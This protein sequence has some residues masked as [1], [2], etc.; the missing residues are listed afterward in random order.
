MRLRT[1]NASME[2]GGMRNDLLIMGIITLAE[3]VLFAALAIAHN[4]AVMGMMVGIII[5]EL[6][7]NLINGNINDDEED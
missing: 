3:A 7:R 5:P 6:I 4:S 1:A 2:D